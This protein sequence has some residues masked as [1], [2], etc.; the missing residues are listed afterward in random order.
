[1]SHKGVDRGE[2][3]TLAATKILG[4]LAVVDDAKA[5]SLAKVYRIQVASGTLFLLFRL[6]ASGIIDSMEA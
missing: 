5:R 2:A 4:G 6:L 1:M 3:E